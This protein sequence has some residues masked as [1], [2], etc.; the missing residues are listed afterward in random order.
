MTE[1][2]TDSVHETLTRDEEIKTSSDRAFGIVFTVVFA[3]IGL[4]PLINGETPRIWAMSIAGLFLAAAL[5]RPTILAPLNRL[6]TKFGFLLHRVTNPLLMGV[7]F[8][9]AVTPTALALRLFGK[10]PL[11][12]K[13][14]PEAKSYWIDRQPPGP[15]PETMS[16][17]F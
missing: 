5:I 12:R 15:S 3:I 2:K 7:V 16:N 4:W 6:W 14:D 13:K 10:D 11:R 17:Q 8:F 1:D 9:L